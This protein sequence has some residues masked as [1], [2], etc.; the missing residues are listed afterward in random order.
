MDLDP[1]IFFV[2]VI[3]DGDPTLATP[4]QGFAVSLIEMSWAIRAASLL[5]TNIFDLTDEGR[6][7]LL[8]RRVS[9]TSPVHWYGQSPRAI[10]SMPHPPFVPFTVIVLPPSENPRDYEEWAKSSP[11]RPTIVAKS[12]GDLSELSLD[13]VQAQFLKICDRIPNDISKESVDAA[14]VAIKAWK[15]MPSLKLDYQVG[16]HNTIIPNL[17]SLTVAGYEEMVSGRF[18]EV[19]ATLKP[20]IEQ[21]VKTSN[22]IFDERAK[23][24]ERDLQRIF[25]RPPDLNLFAPAV[26][27]DFFTIPLPLDMDKALRRDTLVVRRALERQTGY[28]FDLK[29]EAQKSAMIGKIVRGDDGQI[30]TRP[31]PLIAARASELILNTDLMCALTASEFFVCTRLPNEINRTIGSVRNFAQQYRSKEARS[32]KRLLAF[33]Q[34][35]ARLAGA[36]PTEFM[37]LVHRSESGIRIISDAHLEWLDVDGLPLFIRKNCSRIPVTPGNLFVDHLANKRRVH[38]TPQDF[39]S[40]LVLNA[41]KREDPIAGLLETAFEVFEPQWR[42]NLTVTYKTVTSEAELIDALNGFKGPMVIFNGHG[43]HTADEPAKLH[44]G[45]EAV[46]VWGLRDRI[47]NIPPIVVLS[48]CDTHAA[49]RNHATTANG[50]MSLGA[51]AV[52][53]SVFP[54]DARDAASFA[55]RLVYRVSEFVPGAIKVFDQAITWTEVISGLIRMQLLTDYLKLLEDKKAIDHDAYMRIHLEGNQAIN[56]RADDPFGAVLGA[57]EKIGLTKSSLKLDLEITVANSSALSYLLIGRPETII[58]DDR[59]RV[60]GQLNELDQ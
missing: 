28:A 34:V 37:D 42:K 26:Y 44:L 16:G 15:P 20:Y 53:S 43:S 6:E 31:N 24:G 3:P 40:V 41:L 17:T 33:R 57:L 60:V 39:S 9:G 46:D 51:R 7:V 49:D 35:Q 4:T 52:L 55:A 50:F 1:R 19:G 59:D 8:A 10:R 12:G 47:H 30:A 54:L 13:A 21:I 36:V 5:P 56:G 38:L 14:R 48:A 18:Q 22:S 2:I 29:T 27:P 11:L 45:N 32:R 58:I 23:L 25:R